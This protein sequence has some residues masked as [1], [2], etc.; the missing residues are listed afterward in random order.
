MS[1]PET[2]A[3]RV[4]DELPVLAVEEL[5]DLELLAWARGALVRDEHLDGAEARIAQV[6]RRAVITVSKGIADPRRRR[7]SI[8]HELGHLELHSKRV[9][10]AICSMEDLDNWLENADVALEREANE[11]A[12]ALLMPERFFV[13]PCRGREPSLSLIGELADTFNTSL[14]ATAIRYARLSDEPVV[15]I[16]SEEGHIRWFRGSHQYEVLR[17]ELRLFIDVRSRLDSATRAAMVLRG[18]E[19]PSEMMRVPVSAWFKGGRYRGD[20][21]L[22]EQSLAMPSYDAILSL[23]WIR[24]NIE[25]DEDKPENTDDDDEWMPSWR[26]T[27]EW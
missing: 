8:A 2:A 7:F 12:A 18:H 23:V 26:R 22:L 10:L 13:P 27:R 25:E 20:S 14:T 9:P 17:E 3:E 16:L 19:A 6:G 15:V 24:D 21:T 5:A 4:L 1:Y 11:F